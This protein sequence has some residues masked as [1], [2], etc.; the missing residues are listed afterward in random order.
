MS[1]ARCNGGNTDPSRIRT[2]ISTG[3]SFLVAPSRSAVGAIVKERRRNA[4][5]P[6][7]SSIVPRRLQ[8]VLRPMDL[9]CWLSRSP[10]LHA[11]A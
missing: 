4:A 7:A 2:W 8:D 5:L 6:H 11:A 1:L 3:M 10:P 9:L